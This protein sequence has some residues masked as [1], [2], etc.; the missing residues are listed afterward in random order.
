[1]KRLIILLV[2]FYCDNLFGQISDFRNYQ[3]KI[4]IAEMNLIKGKKTKH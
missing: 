4:N 2:I 1:M 3:E